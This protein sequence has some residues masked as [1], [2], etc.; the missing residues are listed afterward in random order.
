[1][2][3]E[4]FPKWH[5]N[6]VAIVKLISLN[7]FRRVCCCGPYTVPTDSCPLYLNLAT[8]ALPKPCSRHNT[9]SRA[10]ALTSG[11]KTLPF[12]EWI[13]YSGKLTTYCLIWYSIMR[14]CHSGPRSLIHLYHILCI[15]A[16]NLFRLFVRKETCLPLS[17][18]HCFE[19]SPLCYN[20]SPSLM[21]RKDA[22][23]WLTILVKVW[24]NGNFFHWNES[25]TTADL[26]LLQNAA[27]TR[28]TATSLTCLAM[29]C[30][31]IGYWGSRGDWEDRLG[32]CRQSF[33]EELN[34][35]G[36]GDFQC[37]PSLGP[38][39][40]ARCLSHTSSRSYRDC[41]LG[42]Q[43]NCPHTGGLYHPRLVPYRPELAQ[44][45]KIEADNKS[46]PN[47]FL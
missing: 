17:L 44:M 38:S 16:L 36:F 22:R 35:K 28:N 23:L 15:F 33:D 45:S 19:P 39:A 9:A 3:D 29:K 37:W 26:N 21:T 11:Q 43:R 41:G 1:M 47:T 25:L 46:V 34:A 42:W 4:L 7:Y 14:L 12:C 30:T 24:G 6:C 32:S 31:R 20:E 18:C 2:N 27:C 10:H 40:C 8:V 13:I 5:T